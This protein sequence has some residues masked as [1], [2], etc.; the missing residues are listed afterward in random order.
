MGTLVLGLALAAG[1]SPALL[2]WARHVAAEPATAYVL[3]FPLLLLAASRST[4]PTPPDRRL[5]LLLFALAMAVQVVAFGGGV[6]RVGR[7]AIPLAIIG[8]LRFTGA[9]SLAPAALAA[10]IVPVPHALASAAPLEEVWRAFAELLLAPAGPALKLD[11]W[12]SGARLIA[13]FAGL[14]WYAEARSGG[15]WRTSLRRG[16]QLAMLG[17]PLQLAATIVAVAL[18]RAG[19]VTAARGFLTHGVWILCAGVTIGALELSRRREVP[20]G[21]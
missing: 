4:E 13:L 5:G 3:T 14:G 21:V 8:F 20:I 17:L 19:A 9:A 10:F 7:L 15:T 11:G 18:S 1:L 16:A 6:E 12:D 2:E